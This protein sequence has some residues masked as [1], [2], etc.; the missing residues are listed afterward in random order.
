MSD[1]VDMLGMPLPMHPMSSEMCNDQGMMGSP[2]RLPVNRP[3]VSSQT[4]RV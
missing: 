3:E 4:H 2:L 1:L